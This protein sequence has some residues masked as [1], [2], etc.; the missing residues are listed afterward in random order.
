LYG[1]KNYVFIISQWNDKLINEAYIITLLSFIFFI[2]GWGINKKRYVFK[3]LKE[4]KK[5]RLVRIAVVFFA[6]GIFSLYN[7]YDGFDE[8]LSSIYLTD[9]INK[10]DS[11]K[12]VFDLIVQLT[13][14]FLPFSILIFSAILFSKGKKTKRKYLFLIPLIFLLVLSSLSSNRASMLYPIL[15]LFAGIVPFNFN[16]NP[17][18]A[19]FL[20]SVLFIITISLENIR[21]SKIRDV[22]YNLEDSIV[23]NVQVYFHGPQFV[24]PVLKEKIFTN[25]TFIPSLLESLPYFGLD[26]RNR[27]GSYMY[28]KMVYNYTGV[29]DQVMPTSSELYYNFGYFGLI[30]GFLIIGYFY[31]Y[32]QI[33]FQ[34]IPS[35][36]VLLR[37]IVFYLTLLFN[38]TIFLS[39]SV[40]GQFVFYL[41][42]IPL[43]II[44][45]LRKN[46]KIT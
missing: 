2:I 39:F 30:L 33:F 6:I 16:F 25:F 15:A 45:L 7:S 20:I 29:R 31:R 46:Y 40:F 26:Y 8:Y 42:F 10:S 37:S 21:I 5:S 41:S 14:S 44:F 36:F 13:R 17:L 27:S 24:Q 9:F 23:E 11:K 35:S 18:R 12:T 28:N 43:I 3:N 38:A 4:I 19:L 32:F 1:L 22:K 34:V